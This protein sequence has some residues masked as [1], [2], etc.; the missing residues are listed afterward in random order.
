[1]QFRLAYCVVAGSALAYTWGYGPH[2]YSLATAAP[3]R[4]SAAAIVAGS[5][6]PTTSHGRTRNTLPVVT[7]A[8]AGTVD[9]VISGRDVV[10]TLHVAN[11]SARKIELDFP[12][13][14]MHDLVVLDASGHEVWRWSAGQLFTQTVRATPLDARQ[15][16]SY[17]VRWRRPAVR[18]VLTAVGT[19]T[20][21]NYPVESRQ[22]FTLPP[23]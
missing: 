10:F 9:A 4:E 18:G 5:E 12:N 22:T 23:S 14:Q 20:S 19:L 13:G 17:T 11:R 15:T 3:A 2:S 7:N 1:M 6:S 8:L 21:N 16:I